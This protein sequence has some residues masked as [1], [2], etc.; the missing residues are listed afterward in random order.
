M[1]LTV[2]LDSVALFSFIPSEICFGQFRS[3]LPTWPH[4]AWDPKIHNATTLFELISSSRIIFFTNGSITGVRKGFLSWIGMKGSCS[5]CCLSWNRT[6]SYM[7]KY[8]SGE[9]I[10]LLCLRI[11]IFVHFFSPVWEDF[12]EVPLASVIDDCYPVFWCIGLAEHN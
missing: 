7:E 12:V 2:V 5:N 10:F 11:S 8:Q 3:K 4:W 9:L 6:F 1:F